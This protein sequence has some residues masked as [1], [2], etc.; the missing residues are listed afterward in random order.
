M[1]IS[2][3]NL[4]RRE[5]PKSI[6]GITTCIIYERRKAEYRPKKGRNIDPRNIAG[7]EHRAHPFRTLLLNL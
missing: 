6:L 4:V 7:A 3:L 5:G 2:G 1:A